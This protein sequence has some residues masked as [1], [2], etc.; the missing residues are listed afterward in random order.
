MT[1]WA[2]PCGTSVSCWVCWWW[3]GVG[4]SRSW[5]A[6]D[7]PC[8][9]SLAST[10]LSWQTSRRRP[11]SARS[12]PEQMRYILKNQTDINLFKARKWNCIVK[13]P[14]KLLDVR[15]RLI[16]YFLFAG[17][18]TDGFIIREKYSGDS[19]LTRTRGARCTTCVC[20]TVSRLSSPSPSSVPTAQSSTRSSSPASGGQSI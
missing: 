16:I 7:R 14:L 9:G 18:C 4:A 10:I 12:E 17:K 2:S 3:G 8:Q 20:R 15:E 5:T 13:S 11:S 1:D 19:T 6:S